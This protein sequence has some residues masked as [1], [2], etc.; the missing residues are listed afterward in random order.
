MGTGMLLL[1]LSCS[2]RPD[3]VEPGDINYVGISVSPLHFAEDTRA[4]IELGAG[5][6][7]F[8][9]E[10]TDTVGI[11]PNQG[12]QAYF[13]MFSS[14]GS[15]YAQFEGGGWA[16]KGN[17][18]YSYS[19]YF[20]YE[21]DT[22]SLAQISWSFDGQEQQ[23][24]GDYQHLS[25][26]QYLASGTVVPENGALKFNLKRMESVMMFRLTMPASKEYARMRVSLQDNTPIVIDETVDIRGVEPV[27]T[28]KK[29]VP[30]VD[31]MLVDVATF[32][33][34]EVITLYMM[35]PPQNFEGKKLLISVETTDGDT[36]WGLTNGKNMVVN[37]G[38]M[39]AAEMESD[40]GSLMEKFEGVE[41]RWN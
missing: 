14:A 7:D 3:P 20:P 29:S 13:D 23:G 18:E 10:E 22:H 2:V 15:N 19:A 26:Y 11:F 12:S 17:G 33:P 32:G 38:Y 21:F 5:Q 30:Y 6:I 24:N 35:L 25:R 1:A 16:L 27:I 4:S 37:Q 31:L 36:C 34:N 9:W 39:Y 40:F 41:G 8:A 28:P